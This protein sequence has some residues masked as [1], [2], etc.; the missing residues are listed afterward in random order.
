MYNLTSIVGMMFTWTSANLLY[1]YRSYP[2]KVNV[3]VV[4]RPVTFPSVTVCN[5][6]HLDMLVVQRMERI[7]N[8]NASAGS[9]PGETSPD[10]E[11]FLRKYPAFA[12]NSTSFLRYMQSRSELQIML[13]LG[14]LEVSG[15]SICR[16]S[17]YKSNFN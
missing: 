5:K 17:I 3:E 12:D 10:V 15:F 13:V 11:E 7:F 8:D 2:K 16:V 1:Q 14:M 6:N 9:S 4:Q